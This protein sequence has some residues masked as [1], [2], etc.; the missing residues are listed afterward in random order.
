MAFSF[1]SA[2]PLVKKKTSMSPGA[3]DGQLLAQ[4]GAR[5][6]GHERIGVGQLLGLLL[7]RVDHAPIA[8]ADVDAHQLRV[9]VEEAL[10]VGRVEVDALRLIDGDR[11]R[12]PTGPTTRKACTC[13]KA[14]RSPR[15]SSSRAQQSVSMQRRL[16]YSPP[17]VDARQR[18]RPG[19]STPDSQ[20]SASASSHAPTQALQRNARRGPCKNLLQTPSAV[21][22]L[23]ER[24]A[25]AA[26]RKD[27]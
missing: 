21:A 27:N 19:R 10:A 6:G 8:V 1:A 23:P 14:R 5:L 4:P 25:L 3:I 13:A 16:L 15:R 7:D 2:P 18:Q 24:P 22:I 9:E 20:A 11:D 17:S 12:P 26:S